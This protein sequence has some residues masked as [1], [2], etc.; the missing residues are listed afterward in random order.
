MLKPMIGNLIYQRNWRYKEAWDAQNA[1]LEMRKADEITDVLILTDHPPVYTLGKNA[2]GVNM[3]IS[4]DAAAKQGIDVHWIDRGGDITFHGPEQL[5]GYPIFNLGALYRDVGRF[6]RELEEAL[7]LSLAEFG[8]SGGRTPGLTGVWVEGAKVAA[9]GVRLSRWYSKHGFALN[10][11][12]DLNYFKSI[13]PCGINDKPVTSMQEILGK[14][15]DFAQVAE[16]VE[17]SVS[18][19]FGFDFTWTTFSELISIQEPQG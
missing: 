8:I 9:I 13:I 4:E 6:L 7:I 1:L 14:K 5:V 12:T 19:V 2:T 16:A 3:L 17:R 11:N 15:I 18:E 10:V